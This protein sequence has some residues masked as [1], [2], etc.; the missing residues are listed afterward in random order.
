MSM[1]DYCIINQIGSGSFSAVVTAIHKK[2]EKMVAIKKIKKDKISDP[3]ELELMYKEIEI[4]KR[5]RHPFIC[6]YY[7]SFETEK[8]LY[9]VMEYSKG[10]TL[11]NYANTC[12]GITESNAATLFSQILSG[13]KYLHEE[14]CICHR[15]LKA[16]NILLDAY[17]RV[18]IIDFGLSKAV[19]GKD[20]KMIT[21]CG[22]PAYTAP[23]MIR[24]SE[25]TMSADIWNLGIILYA[26]VACRLPFESSNVKKLFSSIL[27]Q[28]VVYPPNFSSQLVDL[29]SKM[30]EKN[31]E[32]RITIDMIAQH[33]WL[34]NKKNLVDIKQSSILI[35]E[36]V[37]YQ[38]LKGFGYDE[39]ECKQ[40][41]E[42]GEKTD[43]TV[44][45]SII[46]R[47]LEAVEANKC[48]N[49]LLCI[50]PCFTSSNKTL[51][52]LVPVRPSLC[53]TT[54]KAAVRITSRTPIINPNIRDKFSTNARRCSV[55][56]I[57][58][59]KVKNNTPVPIT[60]AP[61]TTF[62]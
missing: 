28:S 62:P 33:P 13:I 22:S 53:K 37:V 6:Q 20:S 25:Y 1:N 51:P 23:E 10:G 57:I 60:A 42:R 56:S 41:L 12:N 54:P 36:E 21:Q 27:Y 30:L 34:Q 38:Q 9:I 52:K 18:R 59:N 50:Q 7:D 29:L 46:R 61:V 39:N 4:H 24:G 48:I 31:P 40:A 55:T 15:D 8:E 19:N 17:G 26:I 3:E 44:A 11:L 45:F 49:K 2:T 14:C 43:S 16:E 47:E 58:L 32:N 35:P 5:V